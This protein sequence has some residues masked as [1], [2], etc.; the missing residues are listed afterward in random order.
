MTL[1]KNNKQKTEIDHSQKNQ[2]WGSQ[3]GKGREW[4]G[5]AFWGVL[6]DANSYIWNG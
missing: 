1:S 6:L 4:N 3:G 2:T 5:W